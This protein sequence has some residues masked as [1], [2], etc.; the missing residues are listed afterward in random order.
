MASSLDLPYHAEKCPCGKNG[1]FLLHKRLGRIKLCLDCMQYWLSNK[2][3][4]QHHSN[5]KGDSS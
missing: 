5:V 4:R 2:T 1:R 3:T